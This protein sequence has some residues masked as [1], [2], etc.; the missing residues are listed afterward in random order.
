MSEACLE[1]IARHCRTL[2]P[3]VEVCNAASF[4]ALVPT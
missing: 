4:Y 3:L 1:L 2:E